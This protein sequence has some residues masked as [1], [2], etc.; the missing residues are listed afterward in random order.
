MCG[1]YCTCS[2]VELG[3][4]STVTAP[5]LL[6]LVNGIAVSLEDLLFVIVQ[7][8]SVCHWRIAIIYFRR[9]SFNCEVACVCVCALVGPFLI[10]FTA[11]VL[12]YSLHWA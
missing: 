4:A 9:I 2:A 8:C 5:S 6:H 11:C 12:M 1:V 3:E 7:L 10:V